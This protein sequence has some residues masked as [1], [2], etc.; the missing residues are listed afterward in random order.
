MMQQKLM[1]IKT[2]ILAR[3]RSIKPHYYNLS[4]PAIRFLNTKLARLLG[5]TDGGPN[6]APPY[7]L[8]AV[9]GPPPPPQAWIRYALG[10][11]DLQVML[12]TLVMK[13]LLH[14]CAAVLKSTNLHPYL[15][16]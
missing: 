14:H 2:C 5:R 8:A 1:S 10:L 6:S 13:H 11:A 12:S 15:L 4:R 16:K 7:P 3:G 9:G